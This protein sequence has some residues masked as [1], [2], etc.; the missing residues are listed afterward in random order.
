MQ[1]AIREARLAMS[2]DEVPVGAVIVKQNKIIGR[3]H[4]RMIATSDPTG[5][6]EILAMRQAGAFE[7]NYR[8]TDCILYVTLEPCAMCLAAASHAR[9][10]AIV[11]ALPE[12][13]TGAVVSR[14]C[15]TDT[16]MLSWKPMSRSGVC[17]EE[18]ADL[19]QSFFV[20]K[21][22]KISSAGTHGG[23]R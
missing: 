11:Y 23:T 13:K 1:A 5:H 10:V 21:R 3:G 17:K 6:A 16:Q 20:I 4:N 22:K 14:G 18:S 8:L 19:L 2:V 7:G 12:P 15:L 9:I